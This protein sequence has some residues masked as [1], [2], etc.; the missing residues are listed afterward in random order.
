MTDFIKAVQAS[1]Y[2]STKRN[3]LIEQDCKVQRL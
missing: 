3:R 1:L 2:I